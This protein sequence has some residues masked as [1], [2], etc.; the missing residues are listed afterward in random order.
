M[1]NTQWLIGMHRR[2]TSEPETAVQGERMY[3]LYMRD[4]RKLPA[5]DFTALSQVDVAIRALRN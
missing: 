2:D 1:K 3:T 5:L 4:F